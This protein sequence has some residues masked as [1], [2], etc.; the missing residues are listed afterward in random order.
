MK[1]FIIL[2]IYDVLLIVI[3]DRYE[4]TKSGIMRLFDEF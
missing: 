3:P 2:L 4:F 1:Q